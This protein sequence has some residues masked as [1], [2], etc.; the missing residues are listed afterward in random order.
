MTVSRSGVQ[1]RLVA[2]LALAFVPF[3]TTERPQAQTSPGPYTVTELG[4]VGSFSPQANDINDAGQAV[5]SFVMNGPAGPRAFMWQDGL[6]T[7]L[8][9]LPSGAAGISP[10]GR[11]VGTAKIPPSTF[12][13]GVIFENGGVTPL[14]FQ[15]TSAAAINDH[16]QVVGTINHG[17]PFLWDNGVLTE[18]GTLGGPCGSAADINNLA[19]VVGTACTATGTA[20]GPSA[21]AFLWQGGVMTD[22][23]VFPGHVDSGAAAINSSGQI[24]GWSSITDEETYE[25]RAVS[26]I[27]ENGAKRVLPINSTESYANDIND[28]GHVVGTMRAGGFIGSFSGYI[29]KDGVG[30]NLNTVLLPGSGMQIRF[31][32]A[33]NN[34]GQIV[35][36][37][38]DSRMGTHAVLLTPVAADTPIVGV[39]DASVTEG[40]SGTS[41]AT[42][43]ISLSSASSQPVSVS[44]STA[45]G[46][47]SASDF[48]AASGTVTFNPGETSKTVTVLVNGDQ[49]G[50]A[51]ETLSVNLSDVTG[52]AALGDSTG[53]V[54]IVDD[55]A[56][57][58]IND[59]TK[60]E[61]NSN[62]TP[63]VFTVTLSAA[64][65]IP[66][67]MNFATADHQ[68]TA[69]SDYIAQTGSLTFS[70]GQTSKTITIAVRGDRT[71]ELGEMFFV[72]LSNVS[73]GF[74]VDWSGVALIKN[75]DK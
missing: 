38:Y 35:A 69:A 6:I 15:G 59:V 25:T 43:T 17:M 19:Q 5:G 7:L 4:P 74:A 23:G 75:D 68:A 49:V 10:N 73:G 50:E 71:A 24:A 22:L 54:T 34:A 70:P 40:N 53:A 20:L 58:T 36:I 30:T 39:G 27:Y 45:N 62:T 44:F 28:H 31:A 64:T 51:N 13:E 29:F 32:N 63:F 21:H 14:G 41:P 8:S 46:T 26:F 1:I 48:Q 2:I 12:Y 33:I 18:L 65:D 55:E 60:N 61:G 11:I 57:V 47:A 72:N 3:L 56:R 9:D 37:A 16:R 67:T 52:G 66:V 42:V